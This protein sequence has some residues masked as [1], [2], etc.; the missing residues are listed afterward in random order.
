MTN[1]TGPQHIRTLLSSPGSL[2]DENAIA[3][4]VII[5]IGDY[6]ERPCL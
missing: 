3:R 2:T 4:K 1:D 5:Q 6:E